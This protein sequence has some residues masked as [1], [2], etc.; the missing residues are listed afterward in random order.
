MK[1]DDVEILSEMPDDGQRQFTALKWKQESSK[2]WVAKARPTTRL[3]ITLRLLRLG[4]TPKRCP[5]CK[6]LPPPKPTGWVVVVGGFGLF[7]QE[8][9]KAACLEEAA[10]AAEKLPAQWL[11]R[12]RVT[13][14]RKKRS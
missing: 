8:I 2:S 4:P 13:H 6:K 14:G 12:F 7:L 11:R 3:A 1:T 5:H 9:L 10:V